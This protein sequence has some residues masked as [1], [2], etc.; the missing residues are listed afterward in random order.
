MYVEEGPHALAIAYRRRRSYRAKG[1]DID[2]THLRTYL[3][4]PKTAPSK[5]DTVKR[6]LLRLAHKSH[7]TYTTPGFLS[8]GKGGGMAR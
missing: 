7:G 5:G 1:Q 3:P 2:Q 4:L 6:A 8:K